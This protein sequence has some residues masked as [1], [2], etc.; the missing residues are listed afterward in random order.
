MNKTVD[1]IFVGPQRTGTSWIDQVLREH[2]Q[3]CLPKNVKETMFFDKYWD[4][5]L[6]YY[7][8]FFSDKEVNQKAVEVCPTYFDSLEAPQRIKESYPDATIIFTL[9]EPVDRALSLFRHHAAKGR[10]SATFSDAAQEFPQIKS[11]GHYK[12]HIER[13]LTYFDRSKVKVFLFDEIGANPQQVYGQFCELFSIEEHQLPEKGER[14]IGHATMPKYMGLATVFA[15]GAQFLRRNKLDGIAEF[16]KKIG[17]RKVYTG[18]EEKMPELT[19]DERLNLLSYYQ[20]DLK[21]TE[22]LLG[23]ELVEWR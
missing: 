1:Y 13:W 19:A 7:E 14:K 4:R 17:L 2:P 21:Y 8:E 23:R 6:E 3:L 15:K 16:G 5:G 20:K 9:R 22:E 12:E 18:G 11:A 10:V